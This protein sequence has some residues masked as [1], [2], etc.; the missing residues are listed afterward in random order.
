MKN[1]LVTGSAGFIGSALAIRLL[2]KGNNVI[3]FDNLNSYYDPKL[4]NERLNRIQLASESN[5]GKWIF[6][7][8]SLEN[9]NILRDVFSKHSPQIVINL[10]AQAGVRYSIDNPSSYVQSNLVG[11]LNLLEECRH[12]SIEHL[13]FASSSSVYGGN[14]PIPFCESHSVDHPVSLYAATKK[15]NELMAHSY[16]HL[17]KIPC[18]GLRFFTVYGPW[19]R[20]DMAPMIFAKSIM[21]KQPIN[22]FNFGKMQRDFTYIDDIVEGIERCCNKP[23]YVDEDF[24]CLNPVSSSSFAPYRIFNIG[25]NQPIKL[26]KFIEILEGS[27]GIKS[28]MNL[29]PMQP[30]DVENTYANTD[31][32]E[33]WIDFKPITCIENGV[34]KF[35]KWYIDYYKSEF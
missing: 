6:Y 15:A 32:L 8:S 1:I 18:T 12:H 2:E 35:A 9:S 23:A 3:G 33:S 27:L 14:K 16:S 31:L 28:I 10:A 21:N 30:G 13:I 19:G 34:D 11:F 25:N 22:V 20:P 7:K 26:L 4:K 29:K 24:D 5:L 17:Y